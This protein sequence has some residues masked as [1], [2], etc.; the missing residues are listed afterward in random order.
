MFLLFQVTVVVLSINFFCGQK[1]IRRILTGRLRVL[2][3]LCS[4]G[5]LHNIKVKDVIINRYKNVKLDLNIKCLMKNKRLLGSSYNYFFTNT[6]HLFAPHVSHHQIIII[7]HYS[8]PSGGS[9]FIHPNIDLII[10]IPILILPSRILLVLVLIE[11]HL[12]IPLGLPLQ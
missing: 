1:T 10:I 11:T 4:Q 2:V 12:I 9:L 7:L 8:T 3:V 6:T 5:Q